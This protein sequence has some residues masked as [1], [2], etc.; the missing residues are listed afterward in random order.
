MFDHLAGMRFYRPDPELMRALHPPR[1][2]G[3]LG[4][5]CAN[6]ASVVGRMERYAPDAMRA[7]E[8]YLCEIVPTIRSV[9]RE[10][11]G[12]V[13]TLAFREGTADAEHPWR[14]LAQN[15]SDGTLRALGV[16]VALFQRDGEAR[17]SLVGIEE[18]ESGLHPAAS[19]TLRDALR[20]ASADVQTMITSHGPDLLDDPDLDAASLLAVSAADGATRIAPVDEAARDAMRRHLFTAGELLRLDRLAPDADA[21]GERPEQQLDLFDDAPG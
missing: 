11:I 14:F 16:L 2:G 12:H 21:S 15:M 3:P 13:E 17:P 6:V 8:A 18:P 7:V 4:P 5:A 1:E 20:R 10:R 19:A 9:A